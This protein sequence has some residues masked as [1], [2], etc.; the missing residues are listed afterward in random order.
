MFKNI[1]LKTSY[2]MFPSIFKGISFF[3]TIPLIT[4]FFGPQDLGLF[5]FINSILLIAAPL[6]HIGIEWAIQSNFFK[7]TKENLKI[8]FFNAVLVDLLLRIF[9]STI[10]Y[11]IFS[12]Y[13]K[14]L[15]NNFDTS[16]NLYLL[17]VLISFC[18]NF[19]WLSLSQSLVLQKKANV[20]AI[21]EC[22]RVVV[23]LIILILLLVVLKIGFIS[24]FLTPLLTNSSIFILEL[25]FFKKIIKIKLDI[26]KIKSIFIFGLP[27][28]PN[29]LID[30]S[31][32]FFDKWIIQKFL[33]FYSTGI[34]GHSQTY[35]SQFAQITKAFLR[36]VSPV[37]TEN[38]S[39]KNYEN[40]NKINVTNN[41]LNKVAL[42]FGLLVIFH[43]EK[44]VALLTYDKFTEAHILISAW[45]SAVFIFCIGNSILSVLIIK[46]ETK[47]LMHT[48]IYLTA[49]TIVLIF[50]FIDNLTIL[51][52]VYIIILKRFIVLVIRYFKTKDYI[53]FK[54]FL[55]FIKY[56]LLYHAILYINQQ[57]NIN[58]YFEILLILISG[59]DC[60]MYWKNKN[61]EIK[62]LVKNV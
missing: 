17:I 12:N 55:H 60:L 62:Y 8:F 58:I 33:G 4:Y 34:Y 19:L 32:S 31:L 11:F 37:L 59:L 56:F 40:V 27:L 52:I 16:Y 48:Q 29:S 23:F 24:L 3:I 1:I 9:W 22:S 26:S 6:S 30:M 42:F 5:Y 57:M 2:Y 35:Y 41:F 10:I 7:L 49:L 53:E 47:F 54:Y 44:I 25:F 18:I 28:L 43:I 38:I 46:K 61:N 39:N 51:D 36:V 50:Y 13:G 21:I 20:F 15:I 14:H 45:F